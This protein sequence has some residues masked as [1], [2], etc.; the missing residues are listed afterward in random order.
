LGGAMPRLFIQSCKSR[1]K[2]KGNV[3]T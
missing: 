2:G 1:F 3:K